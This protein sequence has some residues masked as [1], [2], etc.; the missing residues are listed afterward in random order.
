MRPRNVRRPAY[1][2]RSGQRRHRPDYSLVLLPTILL[3]IGLI[4]VYAISPGLAAQKHVSDNYYVT[5]QIFTV[6][7]GAASFG[8][9]AQVPLSAWKRLRVPLIVLAGVATLIAL[10][11]PVSAEY[12]AHRWVR[13]GGQSLQSVELIKFAI[14]IC[15][16]AFLADKIKQGVMSNTKKTLQPL[17][18]I[19]GVIG[20]VVAIAQRDLGST[21]VLVVMMAAMA[22]IA[23]LP[24]KR[25]LQISAIIAIGTILAI[26]SIG[27]RRDRVLTFLHP[28]QDCQDAGYQAC[29]ALIAVGSGG[30]VGKGLSHGAQAYGYLPEASND[31]IFAI[32]AEKFG[33]VGVTVLIALFMALFGRIKNVLERAPDDFSRVMVAGILAWLS[34][35]TLINIGAMIG[36]L[37]LKGITLPFISAGGTS[38]I[39]VTAALGLVFQVSHYT[40][41][42]VSDD[43]TAQ[44]KSERRAINYGYANRRP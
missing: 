1:A 41:F 28:E 29:Q 27:Y 26:A 38:V 18:V 15:L 19:L 20:I 33:F 3:V 23:G 21:G 22:Y 39:F 10:A 34:T 8:V 36:L 14:V 42:G 40:T 17:M 7:L 6:L 32:M 13:F 44:P 24:M 5:K 43:Y 16:A 12:P 35:Q 2:D 25:V 30:L 37:P 9:V 11:L 4:V 31:S